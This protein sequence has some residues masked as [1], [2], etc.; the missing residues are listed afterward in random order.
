MVL[1]I[2]SESPW[3]KILLSWRYFFSQQ[4]VVTA[5][6]HLI[7]FHLWRLIIYLTDI[8]IITSLTRRSWWMMWAVPHSNVLL[9]FF[10][11]LHW[12][13]P[14]LTEN[15][16]CC[17]M[18]LTSWMIYCTMQGSQ[19]PWILFGLLPLDKRSRSGAYLRFLSTTMVSSQHRQ[20]CS[21]VLGI[22]RLQPYVIFDVLS[23]P[24]VFLSCRI[25]LSWLQCHVNLYFP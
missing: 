3:L 14:F 7:F 20:H 21:D 8:F 12:K 5:Y 11:D 13:M 1:Q 17:R 10:S 24:G 18:S 16:L 2:Y 9:S 4:A 23:F 25:F 15:G 6:L 22:S 19:K